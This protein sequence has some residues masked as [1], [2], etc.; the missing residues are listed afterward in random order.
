[1]LQHRRITLGVSLFLI[2]AISL[3]FTFV[4]GRDAIALVETKRAD[5]TVTVEE[6]GTL[7]PVSETVIR[8]PLERTTRITYLIDEGTFVSEGDLL[9]EFDTGDIEERVQRYRLNY[10]S[11]RAAHA[12]SQSRLVIVT[13]DV[14]SDNRKAAL[15]VEFAEMAFNKFVELERDQL[16][17]EAELDILIAEQ[18]LRISKE[19]LGFSE[20]LAAGGFETKSTVNRDRLTVTSETARLEKAEGDQAITMTYDLG[21][22]YQKLSSDLAE[23]RK[24]L[25][26]IRR[27]GESRLV[28]ARAR[29]NS[30][31]ATLEVSKLAM[32]DAEAQLNA[33]KL[34]APH[35]GMVVYGGS[36]SRVSRDS[37]IEEGARVRYRQEL[38][39]I[40]DTSAY[41]IAIK[42][43]ESVIADVAPGQDAVITFDALP[44]EQFRGK[45]GSVSVFPDSQSW[46][47][48]P[49]NKVYSAEVVLT[50]RV[51]NVSPGASAKAE[52][53]MHHLEDVITV[54]REAIQNIAGDQFCEVQS[55]LKSERRPVEIG[56]F[57]DSHVQIRSGLEPGEMIVAQRF[58]AAASVF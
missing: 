56:I 16:E 52:I 8:S 12:A 1:M 32:E 21:K 48:D 50:E 27:E 6:E 15:E 51:D 26:R 53:I 40:P 25:M 28:Q 41:K 17:R 35:E 3:A 22:R 46:W 14:E 49:N 23:K 54:P 45:V 29:L 7:K 10:E 57:N 19:R 44:D 43:H 37:M 31:E 58:D 33:T 20:R 38:I 2:V 55:G 24:R 13:S 5:L 34:Y 9:V 4:S 30:A 36:A 42:L 39:T 18:S 11:K 47:G